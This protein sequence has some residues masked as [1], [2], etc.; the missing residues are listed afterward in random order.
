MQTA[1]MMDMTDMTTT[2][3]LEH[4]RAAAMKLPEEQRRQLAQDLEDTLDVDDVLELE[5]EYAAEIERRIV[6]IENGTA[7]TLTLDEVR[8]RLR[9]RFGW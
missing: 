9:E 7:T 6:A 5:P 2:E 3:L 8:A 1:T 4:L